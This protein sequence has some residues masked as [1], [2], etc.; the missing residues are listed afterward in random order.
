MDE[1]LMKESKELA[2]HRRLESSFLINIIT[3]SQP[4]SIL[5]GA[6][7][8]SLSERMPMTATLLLNPIKIFNI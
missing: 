4:R 6:R 2:N 7:E 3:S 1:Q 5:R 8:P